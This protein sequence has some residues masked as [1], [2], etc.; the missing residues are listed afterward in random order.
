MALSNFFG[1]LS[2]HPLWRKSSKSWPGKTLTN[3]G[4]FH[5]ATK[6]KSGIE[7]KYK[8]YKG[9]RIRI[10]HRINNTIMSIAHSIF[11]GIYIMCHENLQPPPPSGAAFSKQR[12]RVW[13]LVLFTIAASWSKIKFL[14]ANQRWAMGVSTNTLWETKKHIWNH[15]GK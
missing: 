1:R 4:V 9:L 7:W 13:Q 5:G 11:P 10:E 2:T 8:A 14:T 6:T 3:M 12:S 15:M